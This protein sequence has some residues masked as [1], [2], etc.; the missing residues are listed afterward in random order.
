MAPLIT[1]KANELLSMAFG[2]LFTVKFRTQDEEGRE[3]LDILTI[4]EDGEEVLL[5]NLSGG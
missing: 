4:G 5:E 3:V 1:A 2:P